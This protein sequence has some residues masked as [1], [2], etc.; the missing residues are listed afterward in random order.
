M[1]TTAEGC[2]EFLLSANG[3]APESDL[4][5]SIYNRPASAHA[6]FGF[7][8]TFNLAQQRSTC[9]RAAQERPLEVPDKTP[10]RTCSKS[11]KPFG[12]GQDPKWT[13]VYAAP[14]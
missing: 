10:A 3:G 14:D 2:K 1:P 6:D 5:H 7:S 13:S 8:W 12:R 11:E 9:G 4:N